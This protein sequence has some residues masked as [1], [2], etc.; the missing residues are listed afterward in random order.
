[1][2]LADKFMMITVTV[3][4]MPKAKAFYSDKLGLKITHDYRQSDEQ[5]WMSLACPEGGATITLTT[6]RSD[7]KPGAISLYFQTADVTTAHETLSGLGVET[8]AL[9]DNLFGPGSG[10]RWFDLRDPD[11]NKIYLAQAHEARA[12]F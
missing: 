3:S 5:W 11:G 7:T 4:D 6:Y 12:P 1:M 10:V 2:Q 9:Q 8:S